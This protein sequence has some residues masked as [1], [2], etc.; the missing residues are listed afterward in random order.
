VARSRTWREIHIK[1]T[2]LE[3][4]MIMKKRLLSGIIALL[5]LST[6]A[7]PAYAAPPS[8]LT[9]DG[10]PATLSDIAGY[11]GSDMVDEVG[12][13]KPLYYY[14]A[15][16]LWNRGLFLGSNGSFN[17]DNQLTRAE[18]VVMTLRILGKAT[19]AEA[20]TNPMTFTDVPEWATPYVAYAA[21]KGITSGYNATTFGANDPMTAAQ[22]LTFVLRAMGYTEGEDFN[23]SNAYDKALSIGLIGEPCHAQYSRSNLF[24][25]DNAAVICY[26]ALFKAPTKS[27][28]K[29]AD[30]ITMPGKPTGAVPT[31]THTPATEPSTPT[32]TSPVT[33]TT[34]PGIHIDYTSIQGMLVS[35]KATYLFSADNGGPISITGTI[36]GKSDTATLTDS[37]PGK[38]Y[39]VVFIFSIKNEPNYT[40][41]S[42]FTITMNSSTYTETISIGGTVTD[43][44]IQGLYNY[45]GS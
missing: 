24:L 7:V 42:T 32:G 27:G 13:Y 30:T 2:Y 26:N 31:A 3:G 34:L 8:N 37:E 44:Y 19:E 1:E 33:I 6:L 18:G 15:T 40:V 28:G 22:F 23:W 39:A 17:L 35:G 45:S 5:L 29:L 12:N 9:W 36:N 43:V 41:T 10:N 38:T 11:T 20:T 14:F 21:E 4:G 25:R 16:E